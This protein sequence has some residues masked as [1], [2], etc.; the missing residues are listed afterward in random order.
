MYELIHTRID[1]RSPITPALSANTVALPGM[2]RR[3][4]ACS[5]SSGSEIR[6]GREA[7]ALVDFIMSKDCPV[8]PSLTGDD[9]AKLLKIKQFAEKE[10]APPPTSHE[11][12]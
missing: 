4:C 6:A 8:S 10:S 5:R 7:P 11:E 3:S 9:K 12:K 2:P 1:I